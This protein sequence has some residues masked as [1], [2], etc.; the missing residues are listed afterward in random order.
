MINYNNRAFIEIHTALD[1]NVPNFHIYMASN[2]TIC[3][4]RR[5]KEF[6]HVGVVVGNRDTVFVRQVQLS[7]DLLDHLC[8]LPIFLVFVCLG[9]IQI[10]GVRFCCRRIQYLIVADD[11]TPIPD[12]DKLVSLA[13][14]EF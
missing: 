13:F 7:R 5:C 8:Q 9:L 6:D 1:P 10:S 2:G 12:I 4:I 3:A 11:L 14:Q